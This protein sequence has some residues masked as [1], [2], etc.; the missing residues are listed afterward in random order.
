MH[1]SFWSES[2][3]TLRRPKDWYPLIYDPVFN[4]YSQGDLV[5]HIELMNGR[6][7]H[8]QW[9]LQ[10]SCSIVTRW[11]CV[12]L[13]DF[14]GPA[15]STSFTLGSFIPIMA[16]VEQKT[17]QPLLLLLEECVAAITPELQ[18]ESNIYPII[19]NKGYSCDNENECRHFFCPTV[20][21]G[22]TN[23]T[24]FFSFVTDVLW[25][26]RHLVQNLNQGKNHQR[27]AY[28]FKPLGLNLGM[29]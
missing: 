12:S 7:R 24:Y 14:S 3:F 23:Y 22:K 13:E 29:R 17:H 8:T 5:F 6:C 21:V 2:V 10:N 18:P 9:S 15:E 27:S 16:S 26:A 19:T 25:T 20:T 4:T 11:S 28:H 1:D